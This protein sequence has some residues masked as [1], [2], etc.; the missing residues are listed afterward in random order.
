LTNQPLSFRTAAIQDH[1]AL[2]TLRIDAY[3]QFLP[4]L[5]ADNR[6]T[7]NNSLHNTQNL[8]D[9]L[10]TAT[11]FVCEH[12]NTIVG[13]IYLVP[14]SNPTELFQSDWTYIRLLGV[15]P[16]YRGMGIA[17]K[18]TLLCIEH[19]KNRHEKTI[20]LHT[21]ELMHE[22]RHIYEHL[23][24]KPIK[25]FPLLGIHYWLYALHI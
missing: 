18:L 5:S 16:K 22:A 23:G 6:E 17:K 24:F 11:C 10:N 8:I 3:T 1:R 4:L 14:S 20:A 13:A 21:S 15:H 2:Q 12:Q 19:A 9:L 7:L 25:Q